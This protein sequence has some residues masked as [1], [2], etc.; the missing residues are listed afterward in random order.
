MACGDAAI[1]R[2]A[3]S[4]LRPP[5]TSA[6]IRNLSASQLAPWTVTAVW[7]EFKHAANVGSS[8]FATFPRDEG[9]IASD[10]GF[11]ESQAHV[12]RKDEEQSPQP[13]FRYRCLE[14]SATL[15]GAPW[16]WWKA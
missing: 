14:I 13:I 12:P 16:R 3:E 9:R 6:M 2:V 1:T 15:A 7:P 10:G 5:D 4:V 8:P 11:K